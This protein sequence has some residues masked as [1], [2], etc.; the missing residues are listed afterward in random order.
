MPV[1][2]HDRLC[3]TS[4]PSSLPWCFI[5]SGR[6]RSYAPRLVAGF[7]DHR[8]E[9]GRLRELAEQPTSDRIACPIRCPAGTPGFAVLN[10]VLHVST[11]LSPDYFAR[12]DLMSNGKIHSRRLLSRA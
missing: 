8:P 4:L 1:L 3:S 7:D 10:G 12:A 6:C 5:G 9:S 11:W 2:S